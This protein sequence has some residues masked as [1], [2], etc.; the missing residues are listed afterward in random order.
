MKRYLEEVIPEEAPDV[1]KPIIPATSPLYGISQETIDLLFGGLSPTKYKEGEFVF[2]INMKPIGIFYLNSGSVKIFKKAKDGAR[3]IVRLS[4]EGS[5]L[6]YRAV[7]SD[8]PYSASA[9]TFQDSEIYCIPK[10]RFLH[11]LERDN[12]LVKSIMMLLAKDL[13]EAEDALLYAA[14]KEALGKTAEALYI[15]FNTY[16]DTS[17][18]INIELKRDIIADI[19]GL[20]LETTIRC[21]TTLRKKGIIQI[22]KRDITIL[23][24]K[25]LEDLFKNK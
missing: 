19:A 14:T 23:D 5:L 9:E 24:K 21:L 18:K 3:K 20:S 6:G 8:E 17:G 12:K 7:I 2:L 10:E 1:K 4:R 11:A 15:L 13:K 16:G 22:D 25:A